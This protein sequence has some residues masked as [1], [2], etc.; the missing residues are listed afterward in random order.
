M[1]CRINS[2]ITNNLY[3]PF[4]FT[5]FSTIICFFNK[6]TRIRTVFLPESLIFS[7]RYDLNILYL[8]FKTYPIISVL[9]TFATILWN[10][11]FLITSLFT[12]LLHLLISTGT[13]F[14]LPTSVLATSAFKL[15]KSDFATNLEL[16]ISSEFLKS[17]FIV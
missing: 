6:S 16:S 14:N 5:N 7:S 1:Q 15:T 11:A 9:F 10:T 3:F 2:Y 17:A 13:V 12:I 4:Y 8:L